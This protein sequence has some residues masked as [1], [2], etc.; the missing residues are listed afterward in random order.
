MKKTAKASAVARV[1]DVLM[2]GSPGLV[3]VAIA[4]GTI[5]AYPSTLRAEDQRKYQ[6]EIHSP[7]RSTALAHS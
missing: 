6:P 2:V 5:P 7:F 1:M 3:D 4:A